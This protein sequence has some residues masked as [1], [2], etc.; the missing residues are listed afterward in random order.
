MKIAFIENHL[1][2]RGTTIAVYDYAHFNETLLG[3]ESFIITRPFERVSWHVDTDKSVYERFEKRFNV[4]YYE[5]PADITRILQEEK[6][7][8]A[9][10]QKSGDPYDNLHSFGKCKLFVHAVFN[11]RIPH[12]DF[13][14]S[15]SEWLN[16]QF[17]TKTPVLPYIVQPLAPEE[18]GNLRQQLGIPDNAVVFGRTGGFEAFNIKWTIR[19]VDRLSAENPNVYF[20]FMHTDKFCTPRPNVI[21][22]GKMTDASEKAK[23]INTCDAMIYGRSDGETFGLAIAEFS[24]QNKPIVCTATYPGME[25][26]MHREILQDK[27]LWYN[28][29]DECYQLMKSFDPIEAQKHDWNAYRAY[30]PEHVMKQFKIYIDIM[31]MKNK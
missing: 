26:L 24:V 31:M 17:K 20:L 28:S 23:F 11:P 2:V 7:D 18:K 30:A 29:E 3:N 12:G 14:A 5:V 4:R 21:H 19:A 27:A 10:I 8:C 15:L 9:Y 16:I 22:L 25:S 1:C 13:F 6:A